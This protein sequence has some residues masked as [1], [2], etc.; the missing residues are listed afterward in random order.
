MTAPVIVRPLWAGRV[1]AVLAVL[2]LAVNLRT[3]VTAMSA[4]VTD[5]TADI[6]LDPVLL[7]VLGGLPPVAFALS[8]IVAPRVS[9]ALGLEA[10]MVIAVLAMIVGPLVR[11]VAPSA[12]V[13][14]IGALLAFAG[15]GFANILLPPAIKTYFPDRI[16][17]M[18]AAYATILAVSISV[19][20]LVTPSIADA[21]GWRIALGS[22]SLLALAALLPWLILGLRARRRSRA[23]RAAGVVPEARPEVVGRLI[24]SRRALAIA[25]GFG[26]TGF[27]TYGMF[28]WLPEILRSLA[29]FSDATA[30]ALL[31]LYGIVGLPLALVVPGLASRV[32]NTGRLVVAGV[33]F[34]VLGY[35]GLLLAPSW[36]VLWIVL[37]SL[38]S[39]IFPL[40]LALIGLRTRT[41]DS[42]VALSG[43]VQT[44]GYAA[45]AAGPIV[46]AALHAVTGGWTVPLLVLVATALIPLVSA[47]WLAAPGTVEDELEAR[48][49][50]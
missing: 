7:G 12:L 15:M 29:G 4:I 13:L 33:V 28:A 8:G 26:V 21:A 37:A 25:I 2:L 36:A 22:W 23:D 38:G 10:T 40:A 27:G 42:A 44:I 35:T 11:A 48:R 24:H 30:G 14:A 50:A 6:S 16:A 31:S 39:L 49:Q 5:V 9:R 19:P 41:A 1:I 34:F 18:T 17:G 20:P 45:S 3:A 43:F 47:V 46:L 32:R